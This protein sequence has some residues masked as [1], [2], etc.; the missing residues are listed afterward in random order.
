VT[1]RK[2]DAR[3]PD[4]PGEKSAGP[5]KPP[6]KTQQ[7]FAVLLI[8][9][10]YAAALVY[11]HGRVPPALN[12][13]VAEESLRAI[14]L[15][16]GPHF[17]VLTFSVGNSAETLYLYILGA[18]ERVFGPTMA[19]IQLT[20]SLFAL[21]AILLVWKMAS[22][23]DATIP[24]W[25]PLLAG[26]GS[27][28]L[29]HYACCGLRAIAAPV[30]L[31]LFAVLLDRT[32]RSLSHK[33]GLLCGA[34]LG[35]SIYA[36]TST[37]VLPIAFALYAAYR[38]I[39]CGGERPQLFKRYA[40]I[41]A[42]AFVVS[43]PNLLFFLQRPKDFLSRG[44]YVFNWGSGADRLVN[45]LASIFFPFYY[46]DFYRHS[47]A[48]SFDFDA[49]SAGLTLP[50]HNPIHIILA[51]GLAIGIFSIRRYLDRPIAVYSI[52]VWVTAMASLGIAGPSVTRLLILWPIYIVLASLGFGYL[53]QR[54]K[55]LRIP[56]LVLLVFVG[57]SDLYTY[58]NTAG[59]GSVEY[60]FYFNPAATAIGNAAES[61]SAGGQRVL[62]IVS[63]DANVLK[64]LTHRRAG[65]VRIFE[66]YQRPLV[67]SEIPVAEFKPTVL[68]IEKNP[69]FNWFAERF[70]AE[71]VTDNPE[72]Y[73]V[74]LPAQ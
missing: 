31:A 30:F 9:A 25:I 69:A 57:F 74:R 19:S 50:G 45:L 49:I 14:Y 7:Y 13:D 65:Q 29:F 5:V 43:I 16:E 46:P 24:Y 8:L 33:D 47:R 64:F 20:S 32:E 21:A 71:L 39:R 56:V 44:S 10:V 73:T 66:V 28:W 35:L 34:V 22:R 27:I 36:Y 58:V 4:E 42:G 54:Q 38:L 37:R 3:P 6:S 48:R 52:A 2:R 68:L 51:A 60:S 1:K 62:S 40:A 67:P 18:V 63:R 53:I 26:A 72:Y 12:N 61:L 23:V 15:T 17:E 41:A 55:L 70:P 11:A 59:A